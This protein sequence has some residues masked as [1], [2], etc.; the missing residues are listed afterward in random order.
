MAV[1]GECLFAYRRG[2]DSPAA[3]VGALLEAEQY[4]LLRKF[5]GKP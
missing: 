1:A 2:E 3:R 5:L 4:G